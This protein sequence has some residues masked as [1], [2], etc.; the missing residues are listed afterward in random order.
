LIPNV[1]LRETIDSFLVISSRSSSVG[2]SG[3]SLML[4]WPSITFY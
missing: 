1:T 2:S 4:V 3:K